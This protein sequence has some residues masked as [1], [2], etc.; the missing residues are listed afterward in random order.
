MVAER[1][2]VGVWAQR[3]AE[4]P[5]VGWSVGDD[6]SGLDAGRSHAV[7][8]HLAVHSVAPRAP[9]RYRGYMETET[10]CRWHYTQRPWG[11]VMTKEPEA[12]ARRRDGPGA[13]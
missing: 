3:A 6:R 8:E 2:P 12:A 10:R 7:L 13:V 11:C 4:V 5:P 9:P 1:L